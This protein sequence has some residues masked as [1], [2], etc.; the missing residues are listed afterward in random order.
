MYERVGDALASRGD[1]IGAERAYR[2]AQNALKSESPN[3]IDDFRRIQ[4]KLIIL[5]EA[6]S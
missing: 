2:A 6:L 3:F 4:N 1:A 5:L